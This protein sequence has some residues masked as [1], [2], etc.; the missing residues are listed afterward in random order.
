MVHLYL[1][2]KHDKATEKKKKQVLCIYVI[3]SR[4]WVAETRPRHWWISLTSTTDDWQN[5]LS[6]RPNVNT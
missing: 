2:H 4:S 6:V 1:V 5:I 3:I